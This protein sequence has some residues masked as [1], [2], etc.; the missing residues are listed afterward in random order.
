MGPSDADSSVVADDCRRQR[1][2]RHS[3]RGV[4]RNATCSIDLAYRYVSADGTEGHSDDAAVGSP[5]RA[6]PVG[7]VHV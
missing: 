5:M 6:A 2:N 3:Q 1:P 4:V 7:R